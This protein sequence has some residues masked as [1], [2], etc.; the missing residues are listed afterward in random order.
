MIEFEKKEFIYIRIIKNLI[1]SIH[2]IQ[3][4]VPKV[5]VE[6]W[7][8]IIDL[9]LFE[10]DATHARQSIGQFQILMSINYY[11]SSKNIHTVTWLHVFDWTKN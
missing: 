7:S 3:I 9:K 4:V 1:P 2:K 6:L 5:R 10:F 11:N 8:W